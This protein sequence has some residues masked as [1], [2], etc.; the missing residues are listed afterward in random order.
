MTDDMMNLRALVRRGR[1]RIC[2]RDDRL[3]HRRLME[4]EV[5]GPPARPMARNHRFGPPSAMATRTE[6]GRQGP[7]PWSC[8]FRS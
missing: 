5:G 6:T 8:A 1:M 3:C 4:M 7:A 2:T